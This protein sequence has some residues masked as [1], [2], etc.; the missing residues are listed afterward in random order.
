MSRP[1]FVPGQKVWDTRNNRVVTLKG[2]KTYDKWETP[3]WFV[4]EDDFIWP[5]NWLIELPYHVEQMLKEL[6][7]LKKSDHDKEMSNMDMFNRL[8]ETRCRAIEI[9]SNRECTP[10]MSAYINYIIDGREV[11]ERLLKAWESL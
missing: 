9:Q 10:R 2:Q 1:D 5:E 8:K 3:M 4:E 6:E 7:Q 11:N